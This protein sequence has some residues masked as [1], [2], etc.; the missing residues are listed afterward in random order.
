MVDES[1]VMNTKPK[2]IRAN[3]TNEYQLTTNDSQQAVQAVHIPIKQAKTENCISLVHF[4]LRPRNIQSS[5]NMLKGMRK[6]L[7]KNAF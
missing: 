3:T 6:N 1:I 7:L 2:Q 5:S 4:P